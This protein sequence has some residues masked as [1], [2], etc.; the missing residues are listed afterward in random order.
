M[1]DE[2]GSVDQALESKAQLSS[3]L[4][5]LDLAVS[6]RPLTA[7]EMGD[8]RFATPVRLEFFNEW[9]IAW[10]APHG[11]AVRGVPENAMGVWWI[12]A[13]ADSPDGSSLPAT[14]LQGTVDQQPGD[15]TTTETPETPAPNFAPVAIPDGNEWGVPSVEVDRLDPLHHLPWAKINW[16]RE[17]LDEWNAMPPTFHPGC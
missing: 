12:D 2:A 17:R 5:Y 3:E 15:G 14:P 9:V 6:P 4:L 13:H 7:E 1:S 11:E 16:I 10:W 8:T